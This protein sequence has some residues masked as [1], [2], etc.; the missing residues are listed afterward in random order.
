VQSRPL[1]F[2]TGIVIGTVQTAILLDCFGDQTLDITGAGN[3]AANK[4]RLASRFFDQSDRFLAIVFLQIGHH[5]FGAFPRENFCR[6][7]TDTA[8]RTGDQRYFTLNYSSHSHSP[9]L[10]ETEIQRRA[11]VPIPR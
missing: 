4:S 11:I 2:D 6:R 10:L 7:P 8:G 5:Y 1:S 9:V 3:I